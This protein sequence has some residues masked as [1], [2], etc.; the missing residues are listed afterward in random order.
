MSETLVSLEVPIKQFSLGH[1][2]ARKSL[3]SQ[4]EYKTMD[5]PLSVSQNRI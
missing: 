1:I 2:L 4:I 5:V 3:I